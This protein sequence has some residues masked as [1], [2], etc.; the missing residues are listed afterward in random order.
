MKI[1]KICYKMELLCTQV[2]DQKYGCP[3]QN[4]VKEKYKP[5]HK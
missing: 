5:T 3:H 2:P 4:K 1:N